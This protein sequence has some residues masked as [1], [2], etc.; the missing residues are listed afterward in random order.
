MVALAKLV[1]IVLSVF[2]VVMIVKPQTAKSMLGF[3]EE[4][5][6]VFGIAIA[7]IIAGLILIFA[8]R[9]CMMPWLV[10][11]IGIIITLAGILIFVLGEDRVKAKIAEFKTKPN[12]FIRKVAIVPL[13]VGLLLLWAI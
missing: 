9:S 8:A 7:R 12:T 11:L 10:M 6:R 5:K 1:G 4:G 3:A 13:A 2:G